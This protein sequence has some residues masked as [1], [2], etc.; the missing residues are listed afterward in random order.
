MEHAANDS[1]DRDYIRVNRYID[2]K[3]HDPRAY[4]DGLAVLY[5]H[6]RNGEDAYHEH[7]RQFR[8]RIV[9]AM[10]DMAGHDR[11][12]LERMNGAYRQS[13]LMDAPVDLDAYMLYIESNR[14]PN[15]Q[16][17]KPRRKVLHPIVN[18]LMALAAGELDLLTISMPPGVGKSALAIF[19]LT[20]LGGRN[21][22]SPMLAVSH[23]AGIVRGM[24]DE[25]LRIINP[26][27]EY[28]WADVFPEVRA[29]STNAKD[30]R[31]DL[32]T[33]K[34]FE[35]YQFTSVGAGN[36]GKLRAA[37]LLYCDDLCESIEQAMSKERLDK[38]WTQYNTDL[39]QRKTG[40][41]RE[42][43]IATR[44]SVHDVIGRLERQE[45]DSPTGKAKFIRIPALND[46]GESNFDYPGIHDKF[47]TERYIKQ[48][49][50]MD[51]VNWR[52]LYMNEPIEREGQ[53]YNADE[54]RRFFELPEDEPDGVVA[55]C[56][57]KAKGDD[58]CF[59]PIMYLYGND[60]YIA[61]CICDNGDPG[62]VEERLA[63]ILV[64]HNV[65][66]CQFE[67]NSAGWHIAEKIQGRVKEL[68]GRAK[69]TTRPTTANK[70]TKIIV[71][72]PAVK[73]RCLFLDG[74]KYKGGSD[75]GRMM[76]MLTGY[77]MAGRNKHD[78]VCDGM[79]MA[80][81]YLDSMN[82]SRVEVMKRP[83]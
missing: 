65:Q 47:T 45:M 59:M 81:L 61:D 17:Y 67:S 83:F 24:Y 18:D 41:C 22:D 79:A 29:T 4:H 68:G 72:A 51:D 54:L 82:A 37:Q 76:T 12:A 8:G 55:V 32:G 30:L 44:W 56:D 14:A 71:N 60:C 33:R 69:I 25:I 27:G 70:E 77:T 31:I 3:P 49:D 64:K 16:F 62:V 23:D 35:T 19:Y 74:S 15:R 2:L 38:L 58:Y 6:I 52:A 66:A 42:L 57:T 63:Q 13:L 20:W 40:E 21:P 75:Y 1:M 53:L 48:R 73:E 26:E 50:N 28:L 5:E 11:T 36:A 7:N 43:H 46:Q 10:R 39:Q 9:A 34:R 78:D 80:V